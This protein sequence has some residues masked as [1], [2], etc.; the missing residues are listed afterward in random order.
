MDGLFEI[1]L[2]LS[3]L[4]LL[5][6]T[7]IRLS[8]RIRRGGGSMMTIMSGATDSFLD[9]EKKKAVEMIVEQNAGKKMD[10]QQSGEPE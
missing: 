2:A 8:M 6:F 4:F 5:I 1:I 7:F 10:E 9:K 3:I